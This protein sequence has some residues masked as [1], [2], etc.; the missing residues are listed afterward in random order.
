MAS[1]DSRREAWLKRDF[2]RAPFRLFDFLSR[3][4]TFL[5]RH[6]AAVKEKPRD[7]RSI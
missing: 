1:A 7:K 4:P 2:C 5:T 6:S 3:F